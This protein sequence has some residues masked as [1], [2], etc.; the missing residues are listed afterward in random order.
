MHVLLVDDEPL[1][2]EELSYL[3]SQHPAVISVAQA[4]GVLEAM[5]KMMEQKPDILFL[6]IHLTDE[7]GFELAEKLVHLTEPPYLVFA[8]AYD[9]YALQAF[10]VNANDYLLKPFEEKRVM[11]IL[12]KAEKQRTRTQNTS[13]Q[14]T[15]QWSAFPIHSDD[16]IFLIHPET[17]QMVSVDERNVRIFTDDKHYST[18]GTLSGIEQKLPPALFIK[19][20]RSF[21]INVTKVK[22]IQPWF[23]HTLQLTMENGEKVP[24]SRSYLKVFKERLN[25]E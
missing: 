8:T 1:A 16:R 13:T 22:E 12:N 18:T 2:R 15:E 25:L 6:D 20:H 3:V 21:I 14:T 7:S 17:V 11:E 19:T 10:Q 4:E 24:V 5:G 23:N 9:D